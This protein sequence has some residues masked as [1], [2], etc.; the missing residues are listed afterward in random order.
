MPDKKENR[1]FQERLNDHVPSFHSTV[2]QLP[3]LFIF[4][5]NNIAFTSST[6]AWKRTFNIHRRNRWIPAN[7]RREW[8]SLRG[9]ARIPACIHAIPASLRIALPPQAVVFKEVYQ[10][11]DLARR[12]G[13]AFAIG[14]FHSQQRTER[15]WTDFEWMV[16]RK[17]EENGKHSHSCH[18]RATQRRQTWITH[19][20]NQLLP[21]RKRPRNHQHWQVLINR[22]AKKSSS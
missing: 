4:P 12:F 1:T 16:K 15:G 11:R 2:A 8:Q 20:T 13:K 19:P 5:Q 10:F 7:H 21:N 22:T 14:P 3:Q 18:L 6:H 9:W 17:N